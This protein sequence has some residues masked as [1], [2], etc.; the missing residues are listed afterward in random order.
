MGVIIDEHM[1][2][3]NNLRFTAKK[4]FYYFSQKIKKRMSF[5]NFKM[6]S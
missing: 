4:V 2:L 1:L 5:H 3:D 6:I